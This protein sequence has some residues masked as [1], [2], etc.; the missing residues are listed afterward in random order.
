MR[1]RSGMRP[2]P[3]AAVLAVVALAA[4]RPVLADGNL[5][6]VNHIIIVMQE[7]HSFDNYFGA[8]PFASNTPYHN[9]TGWGR[10]RACAA[11][12]NTCVDG[13]ACKLK[14]GVLVCRNGNPSN[15]RGSVKAFHETR[16]CTGPDLDHSWVGS[17]QEGN[18]RRPNNMLRSSPNN[19]FVRVNAETEQPAQATDHDTMG[20]YTD[21]DLPF[22]Y[23]LAKTFAISDRY[24][25]AVIGQTFPNRAYFLAGTSFGHLTTNEIL[26]A[27]GYKPIDG[28]IFD[29]LDSAGASW[30]DYYSDLPYSLM[31]H[32]SSGHT[33][34]V[35]AFATDAANGTL[36]AV[37][38]VDPSALEDQVINGTTYETDEHPPAD[39]RAGEYFVSQIITALR[40]SPSWHDSVLFLTYDEHGGF[41]DHVFP[42]A[43]VL[44]D[45][46]APGQCADASNPPASEQPGG[47][48][49]CTHSR[50]I[51]APGLCPAFTPTGPYPANCATF[52]Q[53]GFRLPFVAVSPFAKPHYVSHTIGSHTSLLALIEK[54]FS[55]PS[56]TARDANADDLEDMFDFDNAPSLAASVGTA[57]LPAEPGDPNCPFHGS[58]SGAFVDSTR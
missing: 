25:A 14:R 5:Q 31:F 7:N 15:T 49:T 29:R 3:V 51:D 2:R 16:Y 58:P 52:N 20:Y 32:T 27:G 30:I 1:K 37:A 19:G 11:T 56:I 43:A 22:Y 12:D 4:A 21:A 45:D 13:L 6:N 47:G 35:S 48:V 18:F 26:T 39:V 33:K 38:F 44:P 46:I 28:T 50:T 36:P 41:Y 57:P 17:H 53:L 55:L 34:P 8:L 9:A 24:F 54:R 10:H 40:N 42:P 23:D